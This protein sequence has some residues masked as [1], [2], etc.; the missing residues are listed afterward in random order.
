M[1]AGAYLDALR[2][3]PVTAPQALMAG[4]PFLVLSPHPDDETL[5]LGGAIAAAEQAVGALLGGAPGL[6]Q[7][8]RLATGVADRDPALVAGPAGDPLAHAAALARLRL[9]LRRRRRGPSVSA[10]RDC[11]CDDD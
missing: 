7:R 2:R 3:L 4:K 6:R 10:L 1:T 11:D 8:D 5:G 9:R